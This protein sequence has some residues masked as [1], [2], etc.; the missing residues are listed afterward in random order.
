M[1]GRASIDKGKRAEREVCAAIFDHLGIHCRRG[2][3]GHSEDIGDIFGVPNTTIQV[4]DWA[5][6]LRAVRHKPIDAQKQA[7][8][9]G[10]DYSCAWVRLRGGVW[11][12]VMTPEQWSTVWREEVL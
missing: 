11:R 6:A 7:F 10:D 8:S 12:V 1:P 5:D 3:A 2:Q 9:H 4:A